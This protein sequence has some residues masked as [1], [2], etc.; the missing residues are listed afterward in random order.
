MTHTDT[1]TILVVEDDVF[2]REDAIDVLE[3][4][5]FEPLRAGTVQEAMAVLDHRHDVRAV[6]T[7]IQ[8]P[9]PR[10]GIDLARHLAA[11]R[12]DVPVLVTSGGIP[13]VDLP[14]GSRFLPK[15]YIPKQVARVLRQMIGGDGGSMVFALGGAG[16]SG[17]SRSR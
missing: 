4:E 12:P 9:G 1:P 8:M 11:W 16:A 10:D 14:S 3:Q 2:I 13:A 5:G 6:F 7:D 17:S 15:P